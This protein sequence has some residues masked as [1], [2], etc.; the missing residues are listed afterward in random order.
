[1]DSGLT[2]AK[3]GCRMYFEPASVV[4]FAFPDRIEDADDIRSY[5]FKWD[6]QAIIDG[7][8]HFRKKWNMDITNGG[9]W[10]EF[11]VVLNAKLG[12]FPRLFPSPFGLFLD[13][14]YQNFKRLLGFPGRFL[15]SLKGR[16][17]GRN[18]WK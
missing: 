17:L 7:Y 13:S 5:I 16:F 2:W 4:H 6:T 11:L 15:L 12:V 8:E 14:C 1:M 9:R 3:G 18:L 10:Q